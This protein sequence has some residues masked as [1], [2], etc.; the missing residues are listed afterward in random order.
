LDVSKS[1]DQ[2]L[3]AVEF[4]GRRTAVKGRY[5]HMGVFD[6]ELIVDRMIS[7]RQVEP[8]TKGYARE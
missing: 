8:A 7:M 6:H 1:P 2:T 3:Y 4:I 5:G